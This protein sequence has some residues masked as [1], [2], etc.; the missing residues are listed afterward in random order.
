MSILYLRLPC[1]TADNALLTRETQLAYAWVNNGRMERQDVASA[2]TLATLMATADKVVL[3]LAATDVTLLQLP[4]PAMPE[5]KLKTLLPQLVEEHVLAEAEQCHIVLGEKI[6]GSEPV[7]RR[8]GLLKRERLEDLLNFFKSLG[9]QHLQALPLQ[10]CIPGEADSWTALLS[11]YDNAME[12]AVRMPGRG[13]CAWL[14]AQNLPQALITELQTLTPDA[15]ALT[16]YVPA[17]HHSE[18]TAYASDRIS[19]MPDDTAF[20]QSLIQC[21]Q[22]GGSMDMLAGLRKDAQAANA[23]W[24]T[25]RWPLALTAC[26]VLV[27][28]LA[29]NFDWWKLSREAKSLRQE[30]ISQ[31]RTAFPNE[32]VVV[33]PLLQT[34]QKIAQANLAAGSPAATDFLALAGR[35]TGAWQ[36]QDALETKAIASLEYRD[37][38]LLLRLQDPQSANEGK[39]EI[40]EQLKQHGLSLT[41]MED[42][43]WKIGNR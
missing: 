19:F 13:Y 30:M 23:F 15:P 3:L 21:A 32:A 4:V 35:F 5:G 41:V 28:S 37:A 29:L 36:S 38:S 8:V 16:L 43:V 1:R 2:E 25:W 22:A 42:G 11:E 26:L 18:Y 39:A 14:S 33:D 10:L 6:S 12:L 20:W 31:Y 17:D 9:A 7:Q 34:R 40:A 24:K 27:N